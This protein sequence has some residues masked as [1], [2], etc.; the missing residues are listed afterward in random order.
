MYFDKNEIEEWVFINTFMN[1][2]RLALIR[3][4]AAEHAKRQEKKAKEEREEEKW[5]NIDEENEIMRTK[6]STVTAPPLRKT[7]EQKK[8]EKLENF[9]QENKFGDVRILFMKKKKKQ[10]VQEEWTQVPTN[11]QEAITATTVFVKKT[12]T[13]IEESVMQAC[14]VDLDTAKTLLKENN[15]NAKEAILVFFSNL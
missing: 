10:K 11:Q 8:K 2:T 7:S 12:A 9:V 15:W 6:P 5:K 13:K 1:D 3:K 14:G 4:A